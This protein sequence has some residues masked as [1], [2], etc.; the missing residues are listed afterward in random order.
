MKKEIVITSANIGEHKLSILFRSVYEDLKRLKELDIN[1]YLSTWSGGRNEFDGKCTVCLGGAACLG[2][3]QKED[4]T[5]AVIQQI[6][7]VMY[8]GSRKLDGITF[9]AKERD[10]VRS[11]MKMFDNFRNA[12]Y[13]S[14]I[15]HYNNLATEKNHIKD[16][17]IIPPYKFKTFSGYEDI[18][19]VQKEVLRCAIFLEKKGY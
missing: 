18:K 16:D 2:F 3:V 4:V 9:T 6:S 5:D 10:N 17:N 8:F 1:L 11:M 13:Y 15:E 12:N 7:D 19:V 14:M